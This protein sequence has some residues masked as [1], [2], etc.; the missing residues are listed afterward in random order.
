MQFGMFLSH[1][2]IHGYGDRELYKFSPEVLQHCRD[3]IQLRYRM[4]PYILG[5]AVKS[6]RESLPMARALVVEYQDDPNT[7]PIHDEYLF[8]D[9]I[10]VAPIFTAE[11]TRRTYLP[12]GEWT[13]W[14]TGSVE[15]GSR[16]ITTRS[17]LSSIPLYLREGAIV[18]M[19]EAMNYVGEKPLRSLAVLLTPHRTAGAVTELPVEVNGRSGSLRYEFTGQN[20][21]LSYNGPVLELEAKWATAG[22]FDSIELNT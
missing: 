16:W 7:W 21:R 15:A 22:V 20:H 6:A 5:S 13:C 10:L 4:M 8:G 14:W 12:A 2:R 19:Q 1:S 17:P 18:P 9:S 11:G 3:I